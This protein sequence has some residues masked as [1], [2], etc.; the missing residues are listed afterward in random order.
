MAKPVI[1]G[2]RYSTYVRSILLALEEKGVEYEVKEVDILKGE[3]QTPEHVARHPFEKVP[4]FSHDGMD[5]FETS[6]V[7]QYVDGAFGG[8]KLQPDDVKSRAR[9]HQVISIVDSYAY[10]AFITNIFIP[11]V[12]VPM[13]EGETDENQ[14]TE[15]LP[16]AGKSVA[17]LEKIIGSSACMAGDELSLADLHLVPVYDYFSQ[18][19]EGQELL[20]GAPNLRRWWD[21]MSQRESVKKTRPQLG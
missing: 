19:L 14:I 16:N 6:A 5:L 9:M 15:A 1:Y 21:A 2:P 7:L 4:A 13:L 8:E 18:T 10:P 3:H 20:S 12:V 17:A 11:R